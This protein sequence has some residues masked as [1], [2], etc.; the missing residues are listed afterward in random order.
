MTTYERT[1]PLYAS[2]QRVDRKANVIYG[3]KVIQLGR[4][5][6]DRPFLIDQGTLT[7]VLTYAETQNNGVK[8]HFTHPDICHDGIGRYLG[9]WKNFR[10]DGN[11]I[12]ADLHLAETSFDTP[13]GNLG[14]YVLDVAEEV[15]EAFGVS[16]AAKVSDKTK[17]AVE[18]WDEDS[19]ETIP[20]RMKGISS[21][22]VVGD[23]AATRGGLFSIETISD[24][25]DVPHFVS[26]FLDTYFADAEPNAVA[27]Q[28]VRLI[29]S[30]YG[31]SVPTI[32][33]VA[34]KFAKVPPAK[35]EDLKQYVEAFGDQGYIYHGKGMTVAQSYK[36]ESAKLL[37]QVE[38]LKSELSKQD[39]IASN[40][41]MRLEAALS[42]SGDA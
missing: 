28:A 24:R 5:N 29:S 38:D 32:T 3:C 8:A 19:D 22:D 21:A 25:R 34:S 9:R 33:P 41:K 16:I 11:A 6:D 12:Y 1:S 4:V 17:A 35:P 31:V 23:P 26:Q 42:A 18:D 36:A 14:G 40:L 37:R 30:F 15:P 39:D 13:H 27:R 20:Y 7:Q 2:V 10:Q